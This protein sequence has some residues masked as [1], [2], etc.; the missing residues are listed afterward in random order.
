M[1][2][3]GRLVPILGGLCL[4]MA[5]LLVSGFLAWGR[6]NDIAKAT[7]SEVR[8]ELVDRIVANE[9]RYT[10]LSQQLATIQAG[11]ARINAQ[12]EMMRENK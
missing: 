9:N 11:V 8:S 6:T 10:L 1:Q 5:G 12:I 4:F 3:N 2:T 7:A